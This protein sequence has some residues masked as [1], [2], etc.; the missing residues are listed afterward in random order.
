MGFDTYS[1]FKGHKV[2]FVHKT[3]K[4][5]VSSSHILHVQKHTRFFFGAVKHLMDQVH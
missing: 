3:Q 2:L 5:I 4:D 1:E